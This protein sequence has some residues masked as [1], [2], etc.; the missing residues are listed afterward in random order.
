MLK[1]YCQRHIWMRVGFVV[2]KNFT[3]GFL[4]FE[5]WE[6]SS[7]KMFYW[8]KHTNTSYEGKIYWD[9]GSITKHFTQ[10]RSNSKCKLVI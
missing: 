7:E 9:I 3:N 2:T 4:K 5:A 8:L 10:L 6:C 1:Q